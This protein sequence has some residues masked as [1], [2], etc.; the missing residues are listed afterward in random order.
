M[1]WIDTYLGPPDHITTNADKNFASKEFHQNAS[2]LGITLIAM[3]V[4]AH[5]S[6]GTIE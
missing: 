2:V 4:E 6:I 5:N 3:L 1:C